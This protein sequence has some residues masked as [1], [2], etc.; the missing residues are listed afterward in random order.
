MSGCKTLSANCKQNVTFQCPSTNQFQCSPFHWKMEGSRKQSKKGFVPLGC[1][2]SGLEMFCFDSAT[3][4]SFLDFFMYKNSWRTG[5]LG[6][7]SPC[8]CPPS[9]HPSQEGSCY[10]RPYDGSTQ[11]GAQHRESAW[12]PITRHCLVQL[13][14]RGQICDLTNCA[15]ASV[16]HTCPQT[17]HG[18]V[19]PLQCNA[20]LQERFFGSEKLSSVMFISLCCST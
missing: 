2:K 12:E 20:K 10:A 9:L 11:Q 13:H 3:N 7:S 8:S 19:Y 1:H 14:W 18:W 17:F 6:T 16:T 5:W 4:Q 15:I